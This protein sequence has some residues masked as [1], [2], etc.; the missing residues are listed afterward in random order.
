MTPLWTDRPEKMKQYMVNEAR[1]LTPEQIADSVMELIEEGKYSGGTVMKHDV[2]VKE[3]V[4]PGI[5]EMD[6]SKVSPRGTEAIDNVLAPIREI[7][8]AERGTA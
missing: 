1:S 2:D 6:K 7:M 5:A 4:Y 8:K 3:I